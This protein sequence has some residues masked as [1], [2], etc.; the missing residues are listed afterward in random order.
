MRSNQ[1]PLAL[2]SFALMALA[3]LPALG[4]TS[5]AGDD[6]ENMGYDAIINQLNRE[7]NKAQF[8]ATR[9]KQAGLPGADPFDNVWIHAGVG[10]AAL[11]QT[12]SFA[13]GSQYFMNQRGVQAALGIDLFSENWMAEGTARSFGESEEGTTRSTVQEFELRII[14]KDRITRKANI[15]LG[16]GISGRYL[17]LK[18]LGLDTIEYTTPMSVATTGVDFYVN[19][20]FSV[21]AD[22]NGRFAMIGETLDHSSYDA[23]LRMD[24]HF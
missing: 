8:G 14:F 4:N 15:K 10:I 13:D 23:T 6:D 7:N 18:R 20:R 12:I 3:A 17:T 21:G 16:A 9:A 24:T 5:T 22:I 11:T 19:D 2:C 1:W